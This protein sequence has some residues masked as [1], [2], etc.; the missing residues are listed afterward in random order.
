MIKS[1]QQP[2]QMRNARADDQA[3]HDLMARSPNIKPLG[4]PLLRNLFTISLFFSQVTQIQ[5]PN[6]PS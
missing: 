5:T 4:I 2:K 1:P 3:M 6:I